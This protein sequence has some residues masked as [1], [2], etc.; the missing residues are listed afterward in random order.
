MAI[1]GSVLLLGI[2][3]DEL[4]VLGF[5]AMGL[6]VLILLLVWVRRWW[7]QRQN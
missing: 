1:F 3:T 5:G 7:Q 2:G 4:F 6:A